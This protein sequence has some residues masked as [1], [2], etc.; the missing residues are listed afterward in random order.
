MLIC[1]LVSGIL[2]YTSFPV[3]KYLLDIDTMQ[4]KYLHI[5]LLPLYWPL[6]VCVCVC[7]STPKAMNNYCCDVARYEP[8]MIG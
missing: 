2:R 3:L 1:V 5:D 8:H 6:L 7:A 4:T